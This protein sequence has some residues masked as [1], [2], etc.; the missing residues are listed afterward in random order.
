MHVHFFGAATGSFTQGVKTELGDTFEISAG[1]FGK[2]LRNPLTRGVEKETLVAMRQ[3][4]AGRRR[5]ESD[6]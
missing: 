3:S 1:A 5:E 6:P 4:Q 2:P